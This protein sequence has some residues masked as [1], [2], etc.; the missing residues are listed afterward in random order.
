MVPPG[1]ALY[2]KAAVLTAA[3]LFSIPF[4]H[5][6]SLFPV[7]VNARE[8]RLYFDANNDDSLASIVL[9]NIPSPPQM[10]SWS[11]FQAEQNCGKILFKIS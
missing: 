4:P 8:C 10:Q 11:G 1:I 5:P 3:F 9:I 6:A 2:S 7:A